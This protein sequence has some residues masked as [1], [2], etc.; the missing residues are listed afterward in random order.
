MQKAG[1]GSKRRPAL[2]MGLL[3]GAMTVYLACPPL[4][5]LAGVSSLGRSQE[6]NPEPLALS[7]EELQKEQ[8]V[9]LVY[10]LAW[11]CKWWVPKCD[12]DN[13]HPHIMPS[14][15]KCFAE[16]TMKACPGGKFT[17]GFEVWLLINRCHPSA[18]RLVFRLPEQVI[19]AVTAIKTLASGSESGSGSQNGFDFRLAE[20]VL[21]ARGQHKCESRAN[22]FELDE[23]DP[24]NATQACDMVLPEDS[25]H[26]N[27]ETYND[28]LTIKNIRNLPFTKSS[29]AITNF[30]DLQDNERIRADF[31]Y[32]FTI[33]LP[34][35]PGE[36]PK[37][38]QNGQTQATNTKA[39]TNTDSGRD[40]EEGG[41]LGGADIPSPR[42]LPIDEIVSSNGSDTDAVQTTK[43]TDTLPKAE[44]SSS[45][46]RAAA[47]LF[48][49]YDGL[50]VLA[51]AYMSLVGG[52]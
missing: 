10:D 30:C 40:R 18:G 47:E 42:R 15:K 16:Q 21:H 38:L 20:I 32:N 19:D 45:A 3:R 7:P 17:G 25:P 31:I 2:K 9:M 11:E 36:A 22:L 5:V 4:N 37:N 23:K 39:V 1:S 14:I 34:T 6:T 51:I 44:T 35:P 46:R 33:T 52:F 27:A 49:I 24:M 43:P 41:A 50:L 8:A 48:S 26:V 28:G 12:P 13:G 29:L